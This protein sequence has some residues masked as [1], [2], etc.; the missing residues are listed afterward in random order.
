VD[1]ERLENMRQNWRIDF[2]GLLRRMNG[3][4]GIIEEI[5]HHKLRNRLGVVEWFKGQ[6]DFNLLLQSLPWSLSQ[7]AV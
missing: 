3:G 4:W 6:L 7:S 2:E 5:S 1:H